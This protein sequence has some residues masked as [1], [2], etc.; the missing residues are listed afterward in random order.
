M[1]PDRNPSLRDYDAARYG[2]FL[3]VSDDGSAAAAIRDAA[4]ASPKARALGASP[5]PLMVG[6]SHDAERLGSVG[7]VPVGPDE[8][9]Q[10]MQGARGR[11]LVSTNVGSHVNEWR[12]HE[13]AVF[14]LDSP[15]EKINDELARFKPFAGGRLRTVLVYVELPE[16]FQPAAVGA[17]LA[18]LVAATRGRSGEVRLGLLVS[19]SPDIAGARAAGDA[20]ELA[21][22]TGVEHVALR[23][24]GWVLDGRTR[25]P[26]VLA[27]L[28]PQGARE[29]LANAA[30][31][32][33]LVGPLATVDT[34]SVARQAWT[35]LHAARDLGLDLGK[36]GL[37]PLTLPEMAAVVAKVQPWFDDWTAAPAMYVDSPL[38]DRDRIYDD[39]DLPAAIDRWTEMVAGH[40]VHTAL[41][42][43]V[44]KAE[45]RHLLKEGQQDDLGFL[46]YEELAD[47]DAAIRARGVEPL[48]AGG[49]HKNQVFDIGRLR[50]FGVYVTTA[51]ADKVDVPPAY[52]GDLTLEAGRKPTL[53][54][55]ARVK[56]LLEA[57]FLAAEDA[58][59]ARELAGA[60]ADEG[61][62]QELEKLVEEL[63]R[64]RL[65]EETAG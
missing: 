56:L 54:G 20:V 49:I 58:S 8:Y 48:W 27:F 25:L 18:A 26:G 22:S 9:A 29:L 1:S 2:P 5:P 39:A 19:V 45:G 63:W 10:I 52:E 12:Y 55:V 32:G 61:R 37:V 11:I 31:Q 50:P 7:E 59:H 16:A 23:S 42:D 35:G 13:P 40:G 44:Y 34:D 51:T 57:G 65:S 38:V 60:A 28:D 4:L 41:I 30:A 46:S 64:K 15:P 17:A 33:V 47:V 53:E 3:G 14:Q 24:S 36:Y 62:A 6:V 21:A 43:T